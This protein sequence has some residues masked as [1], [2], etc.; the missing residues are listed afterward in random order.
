MLLCVRTL[1]RKSNVLPVKLDDPHIILRSDVE[2]T[3]DF[4]VITVHSSKTR[5]KGDD[6]LRIPVRRISNYKFCLYSRLVEHFRQFPVGGDSPIVLKPTRYGLKPLMYREVLEFLKAGAG[7]LG[8]DAKRVGLHSLQRSGAMHLYTLG[9]PL[10]DIRLVGDWRSLAV[11]VYLSA[12][13]SRLLQI[14]QLSAAA[15]NEL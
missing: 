7:H 9:V 14:E 4:A 1:L 2:F 10:N 11:L 8:I 6:P 15:L 13:F 12:P 5:K 3:D